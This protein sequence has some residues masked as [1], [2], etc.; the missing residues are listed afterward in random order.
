MPNESSTELTLVEALNHV[1]SADPGP[2][3]APDSDI[4]SAKAAFRRCCAAWQRAFK[5]F[6]DEDDLD[7]NDQTMVYLAS[8]AAA[9]AF[10]SAMPMLAGEDGIRDF[11]ACTAHGIAI[12]AISLDKGAHLLYAAQIAASLSNPS[13]RTPRQPLVRK[14]TSR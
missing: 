3:D 13:A 1:T 7:P 14:T 4:A 5:A 8:K 12:D 6:F 9:P 11:I 2:A 10:C